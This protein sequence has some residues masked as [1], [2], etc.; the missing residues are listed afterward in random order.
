MYTYI[1]R[2]QDLSNEMDLHTYMQGGRNV[3]FIVYGDKNKEKLLEILK[4]KNVFDE[5][6]INGEHI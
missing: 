3:A 5:F 1:F 6:L 4:R 2:E